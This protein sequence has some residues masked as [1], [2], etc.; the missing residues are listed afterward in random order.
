MLIATS[1][2]VHAKMSTVV[3]DLVI[4]ND[5]INEPYIGE[6]LRSVAMLKSASRIMCS[7]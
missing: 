4:E 3:L 5:Q 7:G 1:L 2:M 6:V